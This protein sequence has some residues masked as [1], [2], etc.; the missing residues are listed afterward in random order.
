MPRTGAFCGINRL[1]A[2]I[3]PI[4][5]V[6]IRSAVSIVAATVKDPREVSGNRRGQT[7]PGG[8]ANASCGAKSV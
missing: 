2:K 4:P 7:R 3:R 5:V 6:V 1:S 8:H